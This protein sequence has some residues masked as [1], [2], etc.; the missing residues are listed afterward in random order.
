VSGSDN[1]LPSATPSSYCVPGI[2][3]IDFEAHDVASLIQSASSHVRLHLAA[4]LVDY[5]TAS[6]AKNTVQRKAEFYASFRISVAQLALLNAGLD[7]KTALG[8]I[9]SWAAVI[10]TSS[11]VLLGTSFPPS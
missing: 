11:D 5:T 4:A 6:K 2:C 1:V 3:G 9:S 10:T 8:M 7:R